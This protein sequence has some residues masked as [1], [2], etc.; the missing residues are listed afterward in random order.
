[1]KAKHFIYKLRLLKQ[2]TS[3]EIMQ[4]SMNATNIYKEPKLI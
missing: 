4:S 2:Y 3:T 1:M